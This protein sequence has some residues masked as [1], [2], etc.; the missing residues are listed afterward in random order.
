MQIRAL[1]V[2]LVVVL[3][4]GPALAAPAGAQPVGQS[5]GDLAHPGHGSGVTQDGACDFPYTVEDATPDRAGGPQNVTV[6]EEPEEV[7][8]LAPN[9]AQHMWEIGAQEKVVS[10]PAANTD[11]LEGSEAAADEELLVEGQSGFDVPNT[12]HIVDLDPDLVLSPN[13][14]PGSAVQEL[15]DAGVT[16]YHY[17][18]ATSFRD[19]TTLVDQTGR[20]VGACDGAANRT[21]QMSDR[22]DFVAQATA[23]VEEPSVFYDLSQG[24]EDLYTVNA[25]A[26]EHE[27]LDFAGAE[28]VAAE[29]EGQ[30]GSGYPQ[31]NQETVLNKSVDIVVSPG[32][33]SDFAQQ[34]LVDQVGADVIQLNGD[35][36]SQHAPRTVDVLEALAEELHPEAMEDARSQ[37]EDPPADNDTDDAIENQQNN[38]ES[39]DGSGPGFAVGG[40]V[41]ALLALALVASRRR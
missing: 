12:E 16:V 21:A 27:L 13:V 2:T 32:P 10:M 28:N 15:R 35:L 20:L 18:R 29:V 3:A 25:A 4:V 36:I 34:R 39:S 24:D 5:S 38:S 9:V 19:I 22:I 1:I 41:A 33:L 30:F 8:V 14:I 6:E 11:Y 26:F 17:P 37:A 7:V 23:N 31:I 40:A